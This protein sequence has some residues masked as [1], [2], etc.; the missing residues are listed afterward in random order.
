MQPG[1][2]GAAVGADEWGER[3]AAAVVAG[4]GA[5]GLRPARHLCAPGSAGASSDDA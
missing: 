5:V 1:T 4:G 3:A 2:P